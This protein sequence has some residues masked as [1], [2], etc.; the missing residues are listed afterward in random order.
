MSTDKYTKNCSYCKR[1]IH[2]DVDPCPF[3]GKSNR[4]QTTVTST[5]TESKTKYCMHCAAVIDYRA[6]ICPKCGVRIDKIPTPKELKNPGLAAVLSFFF[7]G[8]GQI[9]CGQVGT[10]LVFM[11]VGIICII[12]SVTFVLSG[13]LIGFIFYPGFWAFNIYH[14]H[15]TAKKINVGE[16]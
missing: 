2:I 8:L 3:C 5:K 12:M 1:E 14:A 6:E 9:Y 4:T 15:Q 7:V 13:N 10:A 16:N 11:I